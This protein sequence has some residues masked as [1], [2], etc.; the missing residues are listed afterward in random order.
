MK[1]K[2]TKAKMARGSMVRY[3]AEIGARGEEEIRGFCGDGYRFREELSGENELVFTKNIC[4][5]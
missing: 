5:D 2:A 3:L 1:V 4:L